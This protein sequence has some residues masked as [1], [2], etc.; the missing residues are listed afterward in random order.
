MS[1]P[2]PLWIFFGCV[3][4][5]NRNGIIYYCRIDLQETIM[6]IVCNIRRAPRG[7]AEFHQQLKSDHRSLVSS[8]TIC[9]TDTLVASVS[10]F[11]VSR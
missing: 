3:C 8:Y 2:W 11:E 7:Q 9:A 6:Q 4:G 10:I 1:G 5:V